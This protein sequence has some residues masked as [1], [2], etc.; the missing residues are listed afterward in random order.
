MS[1]SKSMDVDIDYGYASWTI[2]R[3]IIIIIIIILLNGRVEGWLDG[4]FFLYE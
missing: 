1:V 4:W 2:I 3:P